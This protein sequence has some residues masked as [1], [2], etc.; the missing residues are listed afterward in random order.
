MSLHRFML[1]TN[2]VSQ[3]V[4]ESFGPVARRLEARG[5]HRVCTSIFVAAEL[6]YGAIQAKSEKL[7]QRIDRVL[8]QLAVLPFEQP[9][10]R[11]YADLRNHLMMVG[12]PIGPTD[13]FIAAHALSLDL[14]LVT[15]NV[16]EFSRVPGLK[17]ENWID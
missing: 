7:G 15:D 11:S 9:A 12:Y 5:I 1:D 8:S 13:M 6:R 3:V 2:I 14:T 17:V 10:D 4:R 16:R